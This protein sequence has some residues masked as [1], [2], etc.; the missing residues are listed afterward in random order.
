MVGDKLTTDIKGSL[1][2]GMTAVW[3]NRDGKQPSDEIKPDYEI[4]HLSELHDIIARL[5]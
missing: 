2:V 5:A 4:S 1:S 3:I